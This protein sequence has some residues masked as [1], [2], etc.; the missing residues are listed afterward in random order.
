MEDV[1]F[2]FGS[3]RLTEAAQKIVIRNADSLREH[4]AV[5]AVIEDHCD[6]RG[7][8]AYNMVL[9]EKQAMVVKNFLTDLMIEGGRLKAMSYG[10]ERPFCREHAEWCYQQNRRGHLAIRP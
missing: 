5:A 4:S 9:G 2:E 6:E 1:F 3:W 10:K 7:T 8:I